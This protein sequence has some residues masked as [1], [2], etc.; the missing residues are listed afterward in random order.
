MAISFTSQ[1]TV[2]N[3][4]K[5]TQ[6]SNFS[7]VSKTPV[8]PAYSSFSSLKTTVSPTV[9][10]TSPSKTSVTAP[11][12]IRENRKN[13]FRS[14]DNVASEILGFKRNNNTDEGGAPRK[15]YDKKT[16]K[17][18]PRENKSYVLSVCNGK[19]KKAFATLENRSYACQVIS[20]GRFKNAL[21]LVDALNN[22]PSG[23]FHGFK[24]PVEALEEDGETNMPYSTNKLVGKETDS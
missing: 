21:Q 13:S 16:G 22:C 17:L 8:K 4:N 6:V 11:S 3:S 10:S 9:V 23:F 18:L 5:L 15:N 24:A 2:S 7:G 14:N 12:Q 1:S 20:E 19:V